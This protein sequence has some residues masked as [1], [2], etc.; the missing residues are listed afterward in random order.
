MAERDQSALSQL[1]DQTSRVLFALAL[2][3]VK[4]T[5]DA[6]EVVHDAYC[7][8]WRYAAGY[9]P[10][11]GSVLSWLTLLTRSVAI[12][13]LRSLGRHTGATQ[14]DEQAHVAPETKSPEREVYSNE[15]AARVRRAIR[16]LPPEQWKLIE[17]AFFEGLTHTEL[18]QRLSVPLGT[19]KTRIRAGL[20]RLRLAL[21]D[22]ES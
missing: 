5:A 12:D 3:I 4:N 10:H 15:R 9:D 6:E 16:M 19:V 18:A 20:L 13:R 22:L 14:L 7:R 17:L 21:E 1:Y 8:A 2:R 11:R